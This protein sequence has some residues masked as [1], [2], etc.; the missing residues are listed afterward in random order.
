MPL[1][2]PQSTSAA[3]VAQQIIL[4]INNTF[5]RIDTLLKNGQP[6][7]TQAQVPAIP[8]S[9]IIDALGTDNFDKIKKVLALL[10]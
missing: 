10:S 8:A 2:T 7:N 6:A 4:Q 5:S 9:A 3:I 1:P